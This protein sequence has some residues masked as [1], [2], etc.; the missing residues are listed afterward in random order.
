MNDDYSSTGTNG[1][2]FRTNLLSFPNPT[3]ASTAL[4]FELEATSDVTVRVY[5]L[6][7]RLV[8]TI[9]KKNMAKGSQVIELDANDMATG[10][11]IVKF[12]AGSVEATTKFMK[13]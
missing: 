2:T 10:T 7:G 9:S 4:S 12:N 1:P 6:A 13:M 3:S 8:K 11:Y 5:N